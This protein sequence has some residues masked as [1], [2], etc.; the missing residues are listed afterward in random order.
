MAEK[1][2]QLELAKNKED[3]NDSGYKNPKVY[4]NN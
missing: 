1:E 4:L 2:R 3:K